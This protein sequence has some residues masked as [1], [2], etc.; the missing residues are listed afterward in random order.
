MIG[1]GAVILIIVGGLFAFKGKKPQTVELEF[2]GIFENSDIY[3]RLAKNFNETY[4]HIKIKYYKKSIDSYE[5]ELIDALAA[6]R[7]PDLFYIH[8]TW[9]AKH[10]DKLVPMPAEMM[11]L[12]DYRDTFVDV[13]Y[14][15]FVV[16]DRIYAVPFYVDTLALYYN[17]EHF[18]AAGVAQPPKTWTEFIEVVS[19]LIQK[20]VSGDIT[21]PAAAIGTAKNINR[22]TDILGLLMMQSGAPMVNKKSGRVDL[23]S[24]REGFDALD[25]YTSFANSLNRQY[26]WYAAMDYSIDMFYEG[27]LSMMFNYAY[28]IETVR[29]KQPHL[30]FGI[31]PMPQM[32]DGKTINYAN[33]WAAAVSKS[34]RNYQY[35]WQFLTWMSQKENIQKF[36]DLTG[37]PVS[38]RDLVARQSQDLDL[39][40]FANQ[41]LTAKSWYQ[42]DNSAIE[43]ILADAV[44][45]VVRGL[46]RSRDALNQAEQNIELLMQK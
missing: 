17:K 1:I 16:A 38:R 23:K 34:S 36:S 42:V 46:Q 18:N 30:N 4:P 28:N 21:R 41:N 15:D 33:Y 12:K 45:A 32:G 25:F 26:S 13:V 43:S 11:T 20:N 31:A 24:T 22:S 7:G 27:R 10:G 6:G 5:R 2:W 14:D 40:V 29:A 35:A 39:G 44:E 8:N 37:K 19:R 9:V 3:E